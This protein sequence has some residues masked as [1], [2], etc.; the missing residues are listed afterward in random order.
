VN[1][2]VLV[3]DYCQD[4]IFR[5]MN[6]LLASYLSLGHPEYGWVRC[7]PYLVFWMGKTDRQTES[8]D[9]TSKRFA[10]SPKQSDNV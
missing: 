4:E 8:I 5:T 7:G 6:D 9:S 10:V 2:A 3:S 1:Y